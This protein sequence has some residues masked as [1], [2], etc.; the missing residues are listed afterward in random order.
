[1]N[2]TKINEIV[3][4]FKE[5]PRRLDMEDWHQGNL[6]KYN[7]P[8]GTTACFAGATCIKF[9][10][11]EPIAGRPGYY[12]YPE[13]GWAESAAKILGLTNSQADRLFRLDGDAFRLVQTE[14]YT[15]PKRYAA[16]YRKATTPEGR[17]KVFVNRVKHFLKTKGAE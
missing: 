12:F 15:W 16:A 6:D 13:V 3:E 5:E 14:E 1:M 17:F 2:T 4:Y 11:A 10:T 9:G 7:P 8:C